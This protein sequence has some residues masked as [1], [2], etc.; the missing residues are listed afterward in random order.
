MENFPTVW[1]DTSVDDVAEFLLSEGFSF[2]SLLQ[3]GKFIFW[4]EILACRVL[5]R[6]LKLVFNIE[7]D[8]KTSF[9]NFK[10]FSF[11]L[12]AVDWFFSYGSMFFLLQFK[13]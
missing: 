7:L 4:G 8:T 1:W 2:I 9:E 10:S 5:E 6:Q 12:L 13:W 11:F 3:K